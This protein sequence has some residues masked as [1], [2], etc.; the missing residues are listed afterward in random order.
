[1]GMIPLL[2]RTGIAKRSR[3][4]GCPQGDNLA[5]H[6]SWL[7]PTTNVVSTE[8][9][10]C[11]SSNQ[12]WRSY[13]NLL[14]SPR[15]FSKTRHPSM[16]SHLL[17]PP[18]QSLSTSS[19]SDG[20]SKLKAGFIGWYL[21]KLDSRP[22]LTKTMT[23]S[24]IFAAA[25]FTAQMISSPSAGS[26]DFIRMLRMAGYGLLILGPSQHLWFNYL[27]KILPKR[28]M[29]TTLKKIFLGQAVFGPA[30]ATVFYSYNAVLQGES[31]DEI[32]AR[33]RRDLLP[34]LKNGLL[35]WPICDFATFKFMPVH[36][37]PLVNSTCA[38]V[39]TIYLTFMASLEKA[40]SS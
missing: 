35:F 3:F 1:M 33:L 14:L 6:Y 21:G 34:T 5:K 2:I 20:N 24:M 27:S 18:S 4:I 22:V 17:K 13:A 15:R 29:L 11:L 23:T 30:N 36:L 8:T 37:Q 19:S 9:S 38:Y 39:W 28:D 10:C 16:S 32:M 25:D 31:G 12:T 40:G 7:H 26:L